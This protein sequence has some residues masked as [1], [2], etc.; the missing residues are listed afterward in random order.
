MDLDRNNNSKNPSVNL[1]FLK[2]RM[3]QLDLLKWSISTMLKIIELFI[4]KK[5]P[6]II[7]DTISIIQE[8]NP[9]GPTPEPQV[10][11]NKTYLREPIKM[12]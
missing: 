10:K 11:S 12:H 5:L 9:M 1:P 7:K 3:H 4:K 6:K 8:S 2:S